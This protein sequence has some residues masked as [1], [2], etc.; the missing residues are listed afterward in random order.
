MEEHE[1]PKNIK[2]KKVLRS[3]GEVR[4]K[5][6]FPEGI[7]RKVFQTISSFHVK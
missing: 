7:A 2:K 3:P 5:K 4:I 6:K 1:V